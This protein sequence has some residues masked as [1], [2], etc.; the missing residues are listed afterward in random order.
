MGG[1]PTGSDPERSWQFMQ[2]LTNSTGDTIDL[3][4]IPAQ[5]RPF[6]KMRAER[7]GTE[8]LPESGT[9]TK[10][11]FLDFH[12]KNEARKAA[13]AANGGSA[14]PDNGMGGRGMRG[15][16]DPNGGGW[17]QGGW[18]QGG[19]NQGGWGSNGN[20]PPFEKKETEEEK[21]V[22]MRYGKLPKDL[23][24]WYDELDVDKDGQVSLYEYRKSSK[25]TKEAL[26]KEFMEMDLN[27]DGLI[28]ADEYLRFNRK[29]NIDTKV[30]AY[31]ASDGEDRPSNWGL[32]AP[33]DA[34]GGKP[35]ARGR[36]MGGPG[37]GR[38]MGGPGGGR[39]MGG[40]G[41][42]RG[43]GGPGGG[44]GG[45]Q[46]DKSNADKSSDKGNDRKGRQR[47]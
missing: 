13:N 33:V 14:G 35:D 24:S 19:W 9:M 38:G 26:T 17:N 25:D 37:G 43:M 11:Q 18:N 15:M 12:A 27:G 34:N 22:A 1:R 46:N 44:W 7:D 23:P 4:K 16:G 21:P 20:R 32:G 41:G 31:V 6:L 3:S 8:P 29:K 47:P 45:G 42:G 39:G 28:T 2:R 5:S 40:P 10:A 30:E 36:G